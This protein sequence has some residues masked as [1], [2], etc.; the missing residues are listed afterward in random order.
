MAIYALHGFLGKPTDWNE[1]FPASH[2]VQTPNLFEKE[3]SPLWD[4]SKGFNS[5]VIESS[6]VLVGYSM[7]GRLALHALIQNPKL[8]KAAIIISANPGMD[9][10]VQCS[11]RQ[12]E[13]SEWA[14]KILNQPWNELMIDWNRQSVFDGSKIERNEID[15]DRTSLAKAMISWSLGNQDNLMPAIERLEMPI[16]WIAGENDTKYTEIARRMKFRHPKSKISIAPLAGHR[17]PWQQKL[18]FQKEVEQFL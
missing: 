17:V 12:I 4:W 1:V 5:S 8:W 11:I 6:N 16:L 9:D 13:D 15:F 3:I 14:K 2:L 7:G 18:W 10:P